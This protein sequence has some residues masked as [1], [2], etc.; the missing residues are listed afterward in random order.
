M[1]PP[2]R[3]DGRLTHRDPQLLKLPMNPRRAPEWIRRGD[4]TNQRADIVGHGRASGAV[5]AFPGP[6]Q[7]EAAA[8]P[9]EHRRRLNDVERR[10]PAAPSVRQPYSQ[11]T[12]NS[13]QT[14]AWTAG[15]IRNR[16]LVAKC[17]DLQVQRRAR[18][19]QEPQRLEQR[20]D[21]KHD[22][23]S[24][25]GMACRLNRRNMYRVSGSHSGAID[26]PQPTDARAPGSRGAA[27]P[28]TALSIGARRVVKRRR[29][30]QVEPI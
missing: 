6:E 13:R 16:Q 5:S 25:F 7:Q 21:D 11:H 18:T 19:N 9:C 1:P 3:G 26:S 22:E 29:T 4:L 24:L 28:A 8:M 12:I 15:T 20:N 10:A 23:S 30:A 27:P 2:V 14:N 17:E